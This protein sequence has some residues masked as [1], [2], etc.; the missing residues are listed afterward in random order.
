M[1]L[2][3]PTWTTRRRKSLRSIKGPFRDYAHEE[4]DE[5]KKLTL[6]FDVKTI[7][8]MELQESYQTVKNSVKKLNDI[9][10]AA[11][12]YASKICVQNCAKALSAISGYIERVLKSNGDRL[13]LEVRRILDLRIKRPLK[14]VFKSIFEDRLAEVI[15][16]TVNENESKIL[17]IQNFK[18]IIHWVFSKTKYEEDYGDTGEFGLFKAQTELQVNRKRRCMMQV[19]FNKKNNVDIRF[20]LE[21]FK[22]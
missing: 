9:I 22:V 5:N 6:G 10:D 18:D 2:I 8:I 14:L 21:Y 7:D 17:S 20:T 11:N 1:W 12:P 16:L 19:K 3:N 4:S 13:I 15:W